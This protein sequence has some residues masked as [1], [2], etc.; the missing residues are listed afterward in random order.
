MVKSRVLTLKDSLVE[1][2]IEPII[3]HQHIRTLLMLFLQLLSL[4][5]GLTHGHASHMVE[6]KHPV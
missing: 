4:L 1:V 6:D 3:H 2:Y 5:E